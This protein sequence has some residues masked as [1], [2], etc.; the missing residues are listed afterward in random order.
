M[1]LAHAV[2]I[3]GVYNPQYLL[4]GALCFVT[5]LLLV[6]VVLKRFRT[7]ARLW[8]LCFTVPVLLGS[9]LVHIAIVEVKV[10]SQ[11]HSLAQHNWLIIENTFK[12][13]ELAREEFF[14]K[15]YERNM[16]CRANGMEYFPNAPV[17]IGELK[18]FIS[19]ALERGNVLD[20]NKVG[21]ENYHLISHYNE[22]L[23]SVYQIVSVH[24]KGI[25][26]TLIDID[27]MHS[28]YSESRNIVYALVLFLASLFTYGGLAAYWA[29]GRRQLR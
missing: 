6:Q 10:G 9:L 28:I 19:S 7:T 27:S 26:R 11:T 22:H 2:G 17:H 13:G 12:E 23:G 29:V 4:F 18:A 24:N 21:K 25:E 15:C 3:L 1:G 14:M 20:M 8:V 16:Y 5:L